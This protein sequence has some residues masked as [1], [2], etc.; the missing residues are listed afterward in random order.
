MTNFFNIR[1]L[2]WILSLIV[3]VKHALWALFFFLQGRAIEIAVEKNSILKSLIISLLGYIMVKVLLML[4]DIYVKY[5]SEYYKNIELQ[6]QWKNF[7]PR[8]IYK[9]NQENKNN[10]NVLF[11]D[12]F[13]KLFDLDLEILINNLSIFFVLSLTV[14]VF[15]YTGLSIGVAALLI[16]FLLNYYSK[17]IWVKKI[18]DARKETD[19]EKIKILNWVSQYLLSFR[20]ISKNWHDLSRSSWHTDM[21]RQYF[22]AAKNLNLFYLYRDLLAQALVE[23]PYL[24]YTALM[25]VGVYYN[26]LSLSRLFVWIGSSHFM[27]N[28]SN[29]YL[30]NKVKKKQFTALSG[31]IRNILSLFKE[32]KPKLSVQPTKDENLM[33]E[34]TMRDGVNNQLSL[35]PGLYHI[36]G[37]NA[38][39][40]STLINIFLGFERRDYDFKNSNLKQLVATTTAKK[41]RVIEREVVVFDCFNEFNNQ[42]CGPGATKENWRS[43][44]NQATHE[45]LPPDLAA[46]WMKIF[47]SLEQAFFCRKEKGLS[48]GEK[49]LLSMMRFFYSWNNEVNLLI[50][51]ECDAFFDSEKRKLFFQSIQIIANHLA[52]FITSHGPLFKNAE[53]NLQKWTDC[54]NL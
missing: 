47:M 40:K 36:E 5:I 52:V 53:N 38:S 49:I 34:V 21:Y 54:I 12:Y 41:T 13:P 33:S 22:F 28:S 26:H 31:Q 7:L 2:K 50:I 44:I 35:A 45:L 43:K 19:N 32:L 25:I 11:F 14:I 3:L 51:D 37:Q 30:E 17:N 10:I 48:S 27:I 6:R 9:D 24:L 8:S 39:G 18:D 1:K 29:A 16:V 15:M 42:V 4:A 46:E 20:E 23:F